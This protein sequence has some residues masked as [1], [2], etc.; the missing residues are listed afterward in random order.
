MGTTE[1]IEKAKETVNGI[2]EKIGRID[3]CQATLKALDGADVLIGHDGE[4]SDL[5]QALSDD[6]IAEVMVTIHN[7]VKGNIDEAA[8]ELGRI[9]DIRIPDARKVMANPIT[10]NPAAVLESEAVKNAQEAVPE[11]VTLD[12]D[13]IDK[14]VKM[15][16]EPRENDT[17]SAHNDTEIPLN[18]PQCPKNETPKPSKASKSTLPPDEEEK[19]LR[20][21]YVKE[22]KTVKQIA[23]IMGLTKANIYDRIKKYGLRNARYDRDWDG[24]VSESCRR[25]K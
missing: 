21:L 7:L 24:Y 12:S 2:Y 3:S 13:I 9:C 1:I 15:L 20:Q 19:L 16:L 22:Q 11:Q 4:I 14:A 25:M 23:D 10:E 17:E 5:H 8:G 18:E 6:Q